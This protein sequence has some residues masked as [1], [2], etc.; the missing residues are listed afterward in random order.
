M[1]ILNHPTVVEKNNEKTLTRIVEKRV[2]PVLVKPR[3][4]I[5]IDDMGHDKRLGKNFLDLKLD[6]CFSFLPFA[7]FTRELEEIAYQAGRTILLHLPLEPDNKK[8]DPGPG[9][10]YVNMDYKN[11]REQFEEDLLDV[12]HATGINN[13]MGSLYTE[14]EVVM[15]NLL[16][17]V[18]EKELFFVDS[19]T[20]PESSGKRLA[21]EAGIETAR[22]DVFLDN[23]HDKEKVCEQIA[24]LVE[25]AEKEGSAIG[26]GHP[27][28]ETLE[29][30]SECMEQYLSRIDMVSV[31][32][33]LE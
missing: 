20:S 16:S 30:L 10:L 15:K 21:S 31:R 14:N 19:Y 23:I 5:I 17:V 12:P 28:N 3:I 11:V 33:L 18:K 29:G 9:A 6:L 13:H 8:W 1:S 26:I 24:K 4:A 7:P 25:I 2:V 27:V 22:R 32:E